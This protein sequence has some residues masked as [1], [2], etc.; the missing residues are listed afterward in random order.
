MFDEIC[1]DMDLKKNDEIIDILLSK[2]EKNINEFISNMSN[3]E[4]NF[5]EKFIIN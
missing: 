5:I 1:T 4:K 3:Y 2:N